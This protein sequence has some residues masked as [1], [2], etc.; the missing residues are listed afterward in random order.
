MLGAPPHVDQPPV[1]T[2]TGSAKVISGNVVALVWPEGAR[3]KVDLAPVRLSL[4]AF[5]EV[6]DGDDVEVSVRITKKEK[7]G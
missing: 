7:I 2:V 4:E 6:E 3:G 1:K 5:P